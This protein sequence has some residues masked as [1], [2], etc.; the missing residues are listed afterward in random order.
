MTPCLCSELIKFT[1]IDIAPVLLNQ[2]LDGR[3][4]M[5]YGFL[6][7]QVSRKTIITC[8]MTHRRPCARC[9]HMP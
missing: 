1:K 5:S 6:A 8:M 4:G 7:Y 3:S 9:R 2:F